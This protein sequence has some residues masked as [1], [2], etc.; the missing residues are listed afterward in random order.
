MIKKVVF[1]V[2]LA[3]C[4]SPALSASAG[5]VRQP[6]G[7]P[8]EGGPLATEAPVKKDDGVKA[9]QSTYVIVKSDTLWAISKRL[10]NDPFKWPGIWK[11]NPHIEDPDLIYP[12]D[13]IT[14]KDGVRAEEAVAG[15]SRKESASTAKVEQKTDVA[16]LP[17]VALEPP[18]TVVLEPAADA[19]ASAGGEKKADAGVKAESKR[20]KDKTLERRGFLSNYELQSSGV[21]IQSKD[22]RHMLNK[23]DEVYLSFKDKGVVK[24]GDRYTIYAIGEPISHPVTNKVLGRM[25][26]ILGNIVVLKTGDVTEGRIDRSFKEIG[27][28]AMLKPYSEPVTDIKITNASV[29]V[30]GGYVITSLDSMKEFFSKGDIIYID[31]GAKDGLN[32]GNTLRVYRK[33]EFVKDPV[34]GRM[35]ELPEKELG[36]IIV[37]ETNANI[38]TCVIT[39]SLGSIFKGDRVDT[40]KAD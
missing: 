10:L 4:A 20:M 11:L 18:K 16:A 39:K 35:V 7:Q 14:V 31:K 2:I 38:S 29:E 23:D 26:D 37:I 25:I 8:P 32:P 40:I 33:N 19:Q 13:K 21:I 1:A 36:E 34:K 22:G 28:G 24:T 27:P 12:G 6:P 17:V 5:D 15:G 9:D 30:K 3:A